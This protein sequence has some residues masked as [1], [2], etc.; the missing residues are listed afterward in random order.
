MSNTQ[1]GELQFDSVAPPP[2]PGSDAAPVGVTCTTCNAVIGDEYFDVNGQSVCG[3]CHARLL[4]HLQSKPGMGVFVRALAFGLGAAIAGAILYYAV[5]A[6][7]DFEIGLVAIA[8]G[9]MVGYGVR[10]GTHGRGGRRFQV[11]AVVLT[12]LSVSMAYTILVFQSASDAAATDAAAQ[13]GNAAA[14]ATSQAPPASSTGNNPSNAAGLPSAGNT[15]TSEPETVGGRSMLGL[16]FLVGFCL[17]LPFIVIFGSLPGSL[18]SA[19]II[20]FGMQQA[21]RMTM[22]PSFNVSGPFRVGTA[23]AAA[24]G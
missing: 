23:T 18:I 1:D 2:L 6:I 16:L 24:A 22:A 7:T 4:E 10:A 8:I 9:Y 21:W 15:N 5:I 12:Y 13:S 17:L 14:G 3:A 11:L 19:A 20:A